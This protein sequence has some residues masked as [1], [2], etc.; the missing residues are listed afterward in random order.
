MHILQ[1]TTKLSKFEIPF[2]LST[3]YEIK[4]L[5]SGTCVLRPPSFATTCHLWPEFMVPI[6]PFTLKLTRFMTTCSLRPKSLEPKGGRKTQVPLYKVNSNPWLNESFSY[7]QALSASLVSNL[8]P[9]ISPTKIHF[10]CQKKPT[11]NDHIADSRQQQTRSAWL[12][13]FK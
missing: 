11:T 2:K 9:A 8:F 6:P 1:T 12:P 3:I 13:R 7:V 4:G 10:F 5:H